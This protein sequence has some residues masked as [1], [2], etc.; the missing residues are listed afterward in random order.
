MDMA[1]I[2]PEIIDK[3]EFRGKGLEG[4]GGEFS[5]KEARLRRLWQMKLANQMA[6]LPRFE[7]VYRAVQRSF[8]SAG[9]M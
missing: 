7:E 6:M 1:V 2:I 9:L 8:R 5:K 4:I 3:L